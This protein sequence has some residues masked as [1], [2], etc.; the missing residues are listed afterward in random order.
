MEPIDDD[1]RRFSLSL[2]ASVL[3]VSGLAGC[4]ESGGQA[5]PSDAN[6][7]DTDDGSENDVIEEERY[8]IADGT[9]YAT[10]VYVRSAS[11][12]GP[13]AFLIGGMHGDEQPG[14]E[15]A[16]HSREFEFDRGTL[17]VLP[18]ANKPAV[19]AEKRGGPDGDLNRQ[20]P[21]GKEPTTDIARAIWSELE[22]HEPDLVVDMHESGGLFGVE[23]YVGQAIFPNGVDDSTEQ[24]ASTVE[25]VNESI[26]ADRLEGDLSEHEFEV[27]YEAA[28]GA[29]HE[30]IERMLITKVGQDLRTKGWIV[31]TTYRDLALEEQI[32]LH[33]R[34][35]QDLLERNELA[36]ESP[37]DSAENPFRA[38]ET[39]SRDEDAILHD[40]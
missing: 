7:T 9:A 25:Y 39:G 17:V 21:I 23:N 14:I 38:D 3:G 33:D 22:S 12:P 4:S 13:T 37:F 28:P 30:G 26:L 32:Y 29:P 5:E 6:D 10:E 27:G 16:H 31:E 35:A 36:V 2:V 34:I 18:E 24:A 40:D 8:T 11:T 19:E 15:V 1:R 20:F